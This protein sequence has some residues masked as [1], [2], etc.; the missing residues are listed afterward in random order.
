MAP[1]MLTLLPFNAGP[2]M[3]RFHPSFSA[4][5]LLASASGTFTLADAQG[6]SR[7]APTYQVPIHAL[8]ASHFI[9]YCLSCG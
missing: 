2:A 3:M 1:R 6:T 7:Y 8:L 4:T 9:H 5:L